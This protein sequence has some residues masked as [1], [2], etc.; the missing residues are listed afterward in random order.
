MAHRRRTRREKDIARKIAEHLGN[1]PDTTVLLLKAHL[2]VEEHVNHALQGI[3]RNA[4]ALD[5]ARLTYFQKIRL[6]G[7]STTSAMRKT[8]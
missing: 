5:D 1:A 3:L 6:L 8:P 4:E 7:Q 2:I